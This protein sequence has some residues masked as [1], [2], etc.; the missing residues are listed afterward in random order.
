MNLHN[1]ETT[2]LQTCVS[3]IVSGSLTGTRTF[4]WKVTTP[5]LRFGLN[6]R[7]VLELGKHSQTVPKAALFNEMVTNNEH[8]HNM[9]VVPYQFS[10]SVVIVIARVL[11]GIC[12]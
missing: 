2:W 6:Y 1:L 3:D 8:R 7:S 4:V 11:K 12:E 5:F 10:V 9:K